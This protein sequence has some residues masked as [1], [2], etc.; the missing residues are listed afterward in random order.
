MSD[1]TE[2]PD[3]VDESEREAWQAWL[4]NG[5]D[6]NAE[7]FRDAYAGEYLEVESY[8]SE[9]IEDCFD[10]PQWVEYYVDW[11]TMARDWILNGDI[12]VSEGE[13]G[14]VYVFRNI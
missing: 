8:V 3:G 13:A 10:I 6:N 11:K 1:E 9:T 4:A 2:L 5:M 7:D 12:W 14:E